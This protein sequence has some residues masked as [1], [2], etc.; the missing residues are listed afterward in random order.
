MARGGGMQEVELLDELDG[1]PPS[2]DEPPARH[3]RLLRWI[4]VG[5]AGVV[6]GLAGVQWTVDS[7]ERAAVARL[8][9]VPGVLPPLGDTLEVVRTVRTSEA[10]RLWGGIDAGDGVTVSL[11]VADDGAQSVEAVDHRT[12]ETLWATPLL[13]PNAGRAAASDGSEGGSCQ[14]DGGPG[15][16]AATVAC[17]VTD[18]YVRF[19][20]DGMESERVAATTSSVV[21]L[22]TAD[23]AVVA[24]WPVPDRS[25]VAQLDDLVV[26]G[27][28]DL[29]QGI[30]IAGHD[31]ATGEERWRVQEPLD[32][33]V[34]TTDP[35]L[36]QYW[37]F[38]A[39]GEVLAFSDGDRLVLLSRTGDPVRDDL[40][41]AGLDGG[42]GVDPVT[43]DLILTSYAR[44]G[45][46]EATT[47]LAPDGDPA[48]DR[49]VDGTLLDV[50]VDDGS[51]PGLVLTA[52]EGLSAWDRETGRSRWD[53]DV[54]PS[55]GALV[56][57][58]RVIVST[59]SSV[60]AFDGRT[61]KTVWETPVAPSELGVLGTDGRGVVVLAMPTDA[62]SVG[63]ATVYDLA[64]GAEVR[65]I[66]YPE[67]VAGVQIH[68]GLVL[69]WS[70]V[71]DR[72]SLLR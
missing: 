30:A 71:L 56:V 9:D 12:G 15:Q 27:S 20:P 1:A 67:G 62:N 31:A 35:G 3:G 39:A 22:D 8:A 52:A 48:G 2:P 32:P 72:V 36:A 70:Q 34:A 11:V 14:S 4:A 65:R 50:S 28:R 7:R 53:A 54:N 47:L 6:L 46:P 51:V 26:V 49:T 17:L 38:F 55:Y 43:G 29:E 24:Q 5:V 42:Y 25:S 19:T 33:S 41:T 44:T 18:G 13:G 61:G 16:A 23:G 10:A 69:G 21:V 57:R 63:S 58:G 37:T 68:R 66:P 64:T 60:V 45:S 59:S 40:G